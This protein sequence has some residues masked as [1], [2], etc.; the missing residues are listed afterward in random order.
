VQDF[1]SNVDTCS[2]GQY[3][4]ARMLTEGTL[5][6]LMCHTTG[7][8]PELDEA[9]LLIQHPK[10]YFLFRIPDSN[11]PFLTTSW[12]LYLLLHNLSQLTPRYKT[13]PI[14]VG[15]RFN[16]H[17]CDRSLAGVVGL[18][19]AG[20]MDVVLVWVL[21]FLQVEANATGWSLNQR[22]LTESGASNECDQVQ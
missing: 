16:A 22:S 3:F 13:W 11:F 18:N 14:P 15:A 12:A 21:R 19:P 8:Y 6:C 2:T 10:R 7:I 5:S 1:S 20:C 4:P 17:V 9:S